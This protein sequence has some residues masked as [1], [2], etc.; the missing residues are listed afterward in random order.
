VRAFWDGAGIGL[1][2]L[3][4]RGHKLFQNRAPETPFRTPVAGLSQLTGTLRV[5]RWVATDNQGTS[6]SRAG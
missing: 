3:S 6:R 5:A 1:S 2:L 4:A